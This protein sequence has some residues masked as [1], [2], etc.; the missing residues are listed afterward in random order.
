MTIIT[1]SR[2]QPFNLSPQPVWHADQTPFWDTPPE[3]ILA[4]QQYASCQPP[5]AV[6]K[7]KA[8][9]KG[10]PLALHPLLR[11]ALHTLALWSCHYGS[12]SFNHMQA[13]GKSAPEVCPTILMRALTEAA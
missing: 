3:R 11:T 9:L 2:H 8:A 12:R 1:M 5:Q 10:A 6:C 13:Q 7:D 4:P